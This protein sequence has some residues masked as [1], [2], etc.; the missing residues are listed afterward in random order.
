MDTHCLSGMVAQAKVPLSAPRKAVY[1]TTS[2]VCGFLLCCNKG[3]ELG[4]SKRQFAYSPIGEKT[5]LWTDLRE[6]RKTQV[7]LSAPKKTTNFDRNLSFFSYIRLAASDIPHFARLDGNFDTI[8]ASK[9]PSFF[10]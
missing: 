10:A 6:A 7:P 4:A 1:N 8:K 3:L 9:L 5:V 2:I